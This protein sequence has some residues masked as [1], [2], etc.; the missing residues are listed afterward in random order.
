MRWIELWDSD[1][2]NASWGC[3]THVVSGDDYRTPKRVE[4]CYSA[5]RLIALSGHLNEMLHRIRSE[6]NIS[7]PMFTCPDCGVR[8]RAA[9]PRLTIRA[10]ILAV[11]RF[12]IA[13]ESTVKQVEKACAK[14]RKEHG[15]DLYGAAD[16][17]T[18][19][20]SCEHGTRGLGT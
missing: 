1:A 6:Q 19:A 10:I 11:G 15:L 13:P 18:G 17:P 12:E 16:E 8:T 4:R 7:S 5:D 20:R 9:E 3:S 2:L 14:Y